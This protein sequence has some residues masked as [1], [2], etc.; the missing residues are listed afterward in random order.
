MDKLLASPAPS[1]VAAAHGDVQITAEWAGGADLNLALIDAQGK[2]TSWLGSP[3]RATVSGRDVTSNRDEALGI[4]GLSQGNYVLEIARAAG[5]DTGDTARGEVTL[6]LNGETR[7]VP[8]TLTGA[9]AELGTVRVF[10]TSR[11][12]PLDNPAGGWTG[13]PAPRF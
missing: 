12:E 5:R 1:P 9:R 8:F 4:T 3:G 11:L 10:F 2:R 7:K 6:R 13:R